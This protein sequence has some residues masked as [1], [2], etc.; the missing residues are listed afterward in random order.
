MKDK[1]R[2]LNTIFLCLLMVAAVFAVVQLNISGQESP[3]EPL[4]E[5]IDKSLEEAQLSLSFFTENVGQID[6]PDI[7]YFMNSG[8]VQVGFGKSALF[9]KI[10]ETLEESNRPFDSMKRSPCSWRVSLQ[11]N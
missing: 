11:K 7:H 8:G 2:K 9:V 10:E 5:T 1:I 3:S 4:E 6:N